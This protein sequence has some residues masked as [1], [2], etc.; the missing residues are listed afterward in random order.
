MTDDGQN[1]E[2]EFVMEDEI[3]YLFANASPNPTREGCP[4]K[5]TLEE[6]S[7]RARPI[8]DPGYLHL[9]RCSPCFREFRTMQQLRRQQRR[10]RR[11]RALAVAALIVIVVAGSWMLLPGGKRAGSN[12][13]T[14]TPIGQSPGTDQQ[15]QLD[16]RP[17]A[18]TRGEPSRP[19]PEPLVLPRAR[20]NMT[21]LLPVGAEEGTYEL[22]LLDRDLAPRATTE[23]SAAIVNY[24]TTL[25]ATLD[26]HALDPGMYQLAIRGAGSDWQL[27]PT[28]LK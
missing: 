25:R 7:R 24:V 2:S 14:G 26:L 3:D 20:V 17:F 23:G 18:V 22:R 15:A 28:Q 8:G 13:T 6:L 1:N 9:T 10:A 21:L 27:F 16:L 19:A 4:S 12:T 5:E 11:N